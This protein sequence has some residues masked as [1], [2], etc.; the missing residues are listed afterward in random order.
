M[1]A[2]TKASLGRKTANRIESVA[3][4]EGG[5]RRARARALCRRIFAKNAPVSSRRGKLHRLRA[6]G[7]AVRDAARLTRL[8]SAALF[9][10]SPLQ[11]LIRRPQAVY[12]GFSTEWMP[13]GRSLQDQAAMVPAG[14]GC[15][16]AVK[17]EVSY[18]HRII[19]S[20]EKWNWNTP[21]SLF[22]ADISLS[23]FN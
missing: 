9:F 1:S 5:E 2:N 7:S 23:V 17:K 13:S 6:P 21:I 20:T 18:E 10:A 16:T 12:T 4:G 15:M 3:S 22:S 8:L 14:D 19:I 11:V